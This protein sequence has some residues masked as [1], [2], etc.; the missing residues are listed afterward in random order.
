MESYDIFLIMFVIVLV[1]LF[2]YILSYNAGVRER[3]ALK[4]KKIEKIQQT[5]SQQVIGTPLSSVIVRFKSC[6]SI[7]DA[8]L[9]S[10]VVLP[11]G[12]KKKVYIWY[13]DWHYTL[14]EFNGQGYSPYHSSTITLNGGNMAVSNGSGYSMNIVSGAT[15]QK[16][17]IRMIFENDILVAKEQQGLFS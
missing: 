8:I 6:E 1:L 9:Q 12:K 13:L 17:Y 11:D 10:E 2:V 16:A 4:L 5:F 3:N 14:S 7:S 15:T